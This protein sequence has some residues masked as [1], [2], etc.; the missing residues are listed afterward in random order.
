[1]TAKIQTALGPV[2]PAPISFFPADIARKVLERVLEDQHQAIRTR[3][4]L[5]GIDPDNRPTIGEKRSLS[6]EFLA[7]RSDFALRWDA[8]L[9]E[10]EREGYLIHDHCYECAGELRVANETT[11]VVSVPN[12]SYDPAKPNPYVNARTRRDPDQF[13]SYRSLT[14]EETP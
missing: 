6:A 2:T 13:I 1:M 3:E 9:A 11:E 14:S 12:P 8:L 10:G 7:N 5:A 4:I